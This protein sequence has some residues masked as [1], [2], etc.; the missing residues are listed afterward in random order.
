MQ[1]IT[2]YIV[3]IAEFWALSQSHQISNIFCKYVQNIHD[4]IHYDILL[5]LTKRIASISHFLLDN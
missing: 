5:Y 1:L 3:S 2:T 4:D